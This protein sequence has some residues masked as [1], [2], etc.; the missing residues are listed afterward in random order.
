MS[1]PTSRDYQKA[2]TQSRWLSSELMYGSRNAMGLK[3]IFALGVTGFNKE[4]S[5]G[6]FY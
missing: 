2:G 3:T 1:F 5:T 4:L 6:V